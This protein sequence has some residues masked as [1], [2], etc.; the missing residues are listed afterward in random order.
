[1]GSIPKDHEGSEERCMIMSR[2]PQR[3]HRTSRRRAGTR[4]RAS[5]RAATAMVLV[6]ALADACGGTTGSGSHSTRTTATQS[7]ARGEGGT[8][9]EV[10]TLLTGLPQRRNA[11]GNPH[12]PVTLQFFGDLQCPYCRAFA[13]GK[14][15]KLIRQ[16]VRPG[17][18][19]I[20]YRSLRTATHD[21][22]T[23]RIQQ[24]AA[25]AA[26]Q[27]NKLW[28]FIELFYREQRE[29]DSGYVTEAF[30]D[31][32]AQQV[33]GLDLL[34]WTA[35]RGDSELTAEIQRDAGDAH[36]HYLAITP[37]FLLLANDPKSA[38]AAAIK[39]FLK[40]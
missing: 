28:E 40:D 10:A 37:S 27:Q 35:A 20:V 15:T 18:L 22:A 26:G 21:P 39:Q 3:E 9:S 24:V 4:G 1:V 30:L 23:F 5:V 17:R 29:E 16:Y 11:L 19:N 12:A 6:L 33:P 25:L 7:A 36:E 31:N 38:D 8:A 34:A 13:L 2:M 14:L 32:L